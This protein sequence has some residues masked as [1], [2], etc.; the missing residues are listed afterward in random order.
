MASCSASCAF[1]R[2]VTERL[3]LVAVRVHDLADAVALIAR[4]V[5]PPESISI[6][7]ESARAARS[8]AT[9]RQAPGPRHPPS[10]SP[11]RPTPPPGPPK[12]RPLRAKI[13]VARTRDDHRDRRRA[14]AE[15]DFLERCHPLSSWNRPLRVAACSV[16]IGRRPVTRAMVDV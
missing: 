6:G 12:P 14:E 1:I 7:P 10:A 2:A 13:L 16:L 15:P 11:P 5:E 4:E 3:L 9:V 8:A